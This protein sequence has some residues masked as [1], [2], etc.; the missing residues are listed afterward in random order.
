MSHSVF[1]SYS[2]KDQQAAFEVCGALE[3]R[4]LVCWVAARDAQSGDMWDESIIDAIERSRVVVLIFTA[5]SNASRD[6]AIEI[7][8]A[9]R[10]DKTI[11]PFRLEAVEP[12]KGLE[13][14][15]TAVQWHDATTPPSESHLPGRTPP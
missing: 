9:G 1:I 8:Q 14:Y 5:N 6:V 3:A 13:Y 4:G 12:A 10:R 7:K 15:L 11:I 2:S